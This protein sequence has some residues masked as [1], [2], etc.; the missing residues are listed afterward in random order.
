MYK[1]SSLLF[2]LLTFARVRFVCERM[3][4]WKEAV[5]VIANSPAAAAPLPSHGTNLFTSTLG[6]T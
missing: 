3:C 1:L 2:L 5:S 6:A 4:W